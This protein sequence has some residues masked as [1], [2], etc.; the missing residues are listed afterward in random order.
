MATKADRA[1]E[2]LR[3]ICLA[4]PEVSERV[5]H[6][7]PSFFIRD[8]K[9]L[10]SFQPDGHHGQHGMSIWAPAPPGVQEQLVEDE[11]ERFYRPPY[12]GVRGWLGVRLDRDIDWGEIDGIV[13]DSYRL[14]APKTLSRQLDAD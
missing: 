3:S 1:L 9:V 14:V 12:V 2:R 4:L 8:K 6:G 11:P 5:S 10:C 13:R 7:S